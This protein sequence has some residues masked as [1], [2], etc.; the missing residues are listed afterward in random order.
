MCACV[1]VRGWIKEG[2][3]GDLQDQAFSGLFLMKDYDFVLP[4][5][6]LLQFPIVQMGD[7]NSYNSS[8][9]QKVRH[10]LT[11]FILFTPF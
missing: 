11:M 6:V 9:V 5:P 4:Y 2:K 8:F 1:S 10:F 7:G 3:L